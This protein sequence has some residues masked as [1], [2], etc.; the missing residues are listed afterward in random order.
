MER[1]FVTVRTAVVLGI[2]TLL[3]AC[4][5]LPFGGSGGEGGPDVR[6]FKTYE[7]LY[8]TDRSAPDADDVKKGLPFGKRRG[9]MSYG[10]A[11][12]TVPTLASVLVR[13]KSL[14]PLET[15]KYDP[16]KHF[17]IKQLDALDA[18][19]FL[20]RMR[21]A[22]TGAKPNDVLVYVHGYLNDFR[23]ALFRTAQLKHDLEF[24]GPAVAYS[25]PSQGTASGYT[26]DEANAEWSAHNFKQFLNDL[27]AN[28]GK[29]RV[30]VIA[31]SMGNR[32]LAAALREM[33]CERGTAGKLHH[34]ILAAPDIDAD[35]FRRDVMPVLRLSATRVTLY[36]SEDDK[37]LMASHLVHGYERAGEKPIVA[38][39]LD[40]V[41]TSGLGAQWFELFHS[42]FAETKRVLQDIKHLLLHDAAPPARELKPRKSDRGDY[43]VFN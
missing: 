23:N 6:G 34:I 8:A 31:H 30:H 26:L 24:P 11:T 32:V 17:T 16:T 43:W 13:E 41:D 10:S 21:A 7:V 14:I 25:W 29:A 28:S 1:C 4:A 20:A 42:Y 38:A 35:V 40:T 9:P 33:V 15:E 2:A 19:G 12:V 22:T 37:A 36:V 3:S 18:P 5:T 27:T 39:N